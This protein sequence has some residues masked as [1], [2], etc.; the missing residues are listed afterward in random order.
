MSKEER[1]EVVIKIGRASV[2][3]IKGLWGLNLFHI[4]N[5]CH[6][7]SPLSL[8]IPKAVKIVQADFRKWPQDE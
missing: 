8:R 5:C 3:K 1:N 7:L 6:N 2:G 4:S